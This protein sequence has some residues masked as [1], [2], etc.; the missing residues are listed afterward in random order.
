[1]S[2][3]TVSLTVTNNGEHG[4]AV[5][6]EN[7]DDPQTNEIWVEEGETTTFTVKSKDG[8]LRVGVSCPV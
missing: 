4:F 1:M 3:A 6:D 7:N 8:A 5:W 2:A